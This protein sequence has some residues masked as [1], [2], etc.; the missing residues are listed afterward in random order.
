MVAER[1]CNDEL[2]EAICNY[3][4]EHEQELYG[5][6]KR[7][8]RY[9]I[10][11]AKDL[12]QETAYRALS[13]A[14]LY[15]ERGTIGSWIYTIMFHI[16]Q[17]ECKRGAK[18]VADAEPT[19]FFIKDIAPAPD[20]LYALNEISL[21]I[22]S[23]KNEKERIMITRWIQGYTYAEIAKELNMK[24]GTVKSGIFRL[25]IYIRVMLK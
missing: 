4:V 7:L 2:R 19:D 25:K 12:Y 16:F 11:N 20:E 1:S 24:L 17:N 18:V 13:N 23:I 22:A 6:A 5:F 15:K 9:N 10:P 3:L 21:A 8:T 14:A